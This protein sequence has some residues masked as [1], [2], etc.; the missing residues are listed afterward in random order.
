[1][2]DGDFTHQGD[3]CT[4]EVMVGRLGLD[5]PAL[6]ALAEIVHDIDLKDGKYGRSQT[7]GF[8][9]LLIGLVAA[10]PE[11]QE[12]LAAGLGLYENLYTYFR[13]GHGL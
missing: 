10:H 1:M 5:D 12:R 3:R 2:F 9:A 7:E 4:F 8:Q 11:D 6:S 13:R